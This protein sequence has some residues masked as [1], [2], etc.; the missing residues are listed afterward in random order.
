MVYHSSSIDKQR[1]KGGAGYCQ[2]PRF[3]RVTST[4]PNP[5]GPK[6]QTTHSSTTV[7]RELV[8]DE[9]SSSRVVL[10]RV[11]EVHVDVVAGADA[12][13]RVLEVAVGAN[14]G[15]EAVAAGGVGAGCHA[16]AL[17]AG[18]GV[19]GLVGGVGFFAVGD[20]GDDCG[21]LAWTFKGDGRRVWAG[22]TD[23]AV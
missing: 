13:V 4:Y 1:R 7:L 6:Y 18:A 21:G 11:R 12:A 23:V 15:G 8:L 5:V 22:L 16:V 20:C 3:L 2:Q 14:D 9:R 10:V 17:R 19:E